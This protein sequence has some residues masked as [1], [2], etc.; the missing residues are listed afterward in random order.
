MSLAKIGC[1]CDSEIRMKI[2]SCTLN[3]SIDGGDHSQISKYVGCRT[4][5]DCCKSFVIPQNF[6]GS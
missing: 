2:G 3:I 1:S 5:I 6:L 4:E